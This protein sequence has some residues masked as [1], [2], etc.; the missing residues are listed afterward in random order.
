MALSPGK[1]AETRAEA[2]IPVDYL[3]PITQELMRDPV[4]T[5]DGSMYE[6]QAIEHWLT[7]R[8]TSPVT[9]EPLAALTLVPCNMARSRIRAFVDEHPALP[10]CALF[11]ASLEHRF[12]RCGSSTSHP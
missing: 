4:L 10:E 8:T 3:C 9:N 12:S 11:V 2:E 5:C 1:Q 6:R 7:K